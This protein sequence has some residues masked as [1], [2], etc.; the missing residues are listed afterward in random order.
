MKNE[1]CEK[2]KKQS[3]RS[4]RYLHTHTSNLLCLP[5]RQ[6]SHKSSTIGNNGLSRAASHLPSDQVIIDPN[7]GLGVHSPTP[8]PYNHFLE[9]SLHLAATFT[10][11]QSPADLLLEAARHRDQQATLHHDSSPHHHEFA[12]VASR[13]FRLHASTRHRLGESVSR[14]H[15]PSFYPTFLCEA[16]FVINGM[17]RRRATL[18]VAGRGEGHHQAG[19]L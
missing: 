19:L 13:R 7:Q 15:Q 16:P 11:L 6:R 12:L 1:D 3:Q 5:V 18:L 8:L 2:K 14:S 10:K 17:E 4:G 9:R